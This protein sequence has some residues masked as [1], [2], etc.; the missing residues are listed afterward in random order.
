VFGYCPDEPGHGGPQA[1]LDAGAA[2][3]FTRM[4]DLPGLLK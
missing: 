3:L 1:L 4:A 2:Q